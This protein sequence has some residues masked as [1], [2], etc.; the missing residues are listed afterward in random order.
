MEN[1]HIQN[2][3]TQ[4][5]RML[6]ELE[7]KRANPFIGTPLEALSD[8][9]RTMRKTYRMPF[10]EITEKLLSLKVETS[11]REVT[12][13]CRNHLKTEFKKGAKLKPDQGGA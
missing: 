7:Q 2:V 11:L 1:V 9:I 12:D 8:E 3:K 4:L 6:V 10:K 5:A 13:F